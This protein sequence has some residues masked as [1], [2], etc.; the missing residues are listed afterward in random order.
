MA[1]EMTFLHQDFGG[2]TPCRKFI[3]FHKAADPVSIG[4]LVDT[5]SYPQSASF[6]R[7]S[8]CFGRNITLM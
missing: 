2:G 8:P 7:R 3:H 1:S 5:K 6:S 4:R